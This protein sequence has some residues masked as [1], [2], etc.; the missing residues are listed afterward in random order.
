MSA[1]ENNNRDDQRPDDHLLDGCLDEILGARA[2]QDLTARIMQAWAMRR[3]SGVDPSLT[4][5]VLPPL[6]GPAIETLPLEIAPLAT[7]V[8]R[9][10]ETAAPLSSVPLP[11]AASNGEFKPVRRASAV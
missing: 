4:N 1:R 3:Q 11:V 6:P 8:V 5:I 2:P 10:V 7:S 9:A